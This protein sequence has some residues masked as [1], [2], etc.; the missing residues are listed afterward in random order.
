MSV[1]CSTLYQDSILGSGNI[2]GDEAEGMS[3]LEAREKCYEVL[4]S[5]HAVPF[6]GVNSQ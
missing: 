3:E 2:M 1:E 5:G 6:A 4:S